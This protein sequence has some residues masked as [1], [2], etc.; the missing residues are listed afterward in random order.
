[1]TNRSV[2][3]ASAAGVIAMA[4]SAPSFAAVTFGSANVHSNA[5]SSSMIAGTGKMGNGSGSDADAATALT[6][7]LDASSF[8]DATSVG[9][10]AAIQAQ[11]QA[12]EDASATFASAS[13]G[14]VSFS[15]QVAN[16]VTVAGGEAQGQDD[17]E[18][19]NYVFTVTDPST[20]S[21]S[22]NYAETYSGVNNSFI[23][24]DNTTNGIVSQLQAK[25]NLA[26]SVNLSL[27]SGTYT[28]GADTE[29]GDFA[30]Q[31]GVGSSL[32]S[33]SENYAFSVSDAAVSAAPEPATWALM[34]VGLAGIGLMLRRMRNP[35][36]TLTQGLFAA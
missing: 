23:L 25:G 2:F 31:S 28:F 27:A 9:P 35:A 11:S 21:L 33:H 20:F 24:I 29:V 22:Y 34:F 5:L 1:M 13:S 8:A 26:N 19:F 18:N 3:L 17:G 16:S 32:G 12:S 36:K 14:T 15:G 4:L 6:T 30:F 7:S 10:K